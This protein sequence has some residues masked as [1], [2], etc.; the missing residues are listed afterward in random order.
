MTEPLA[1]PEP[2]AAADPAAPR[3]RGAWLWLLPAGWLAQVFVRLLLTRGLNAPPVY[4]DEAGYLIAARWFTGG[5]AADLSGGTF[6]QGGY[7]LLLTPAYLLGDDPVTVYRLALGINALIGATA[8]PL[9]F[10]ALRRLGLGRA[11][12]LALAWTA[13][14]LPAT[15]FWGGVAMSD[16]LLPVLVLGCLLCLDRFLRTHGAGAGAAASALA[17]YAMTVHS[18]GTVVLAVHGLV[19]AASA[20]R[21]DTRRAAL[22]GAGTA[23]L[24]VGAAVYFN[25]VVRDRLYPSGSFQGSDL[26]W[27]RLTTLDGQGWALAGAVGQLWAMLAATWMLGGIGLV[28]LWVVAGRRDTPYAD[29]VM[30][31]VVL[32]TTAGIAYATAAGL[33]DEIRY[34]NH[35]YGRYLSCLAFVYLLVGLAA[36]VRMARVA[37]PAALAVLA[38]AACGTVVAWRTSG[39]KPT[40]HIYL[41]FD[42]PEVGLLGG[43]WTGLK[44]FWTTLTACGLLVLFCALRR[45]GPA[46]LVGLLLTANLTAGMLMPVVLLE[47]RAQE[48]PP[49]GEA[50]RGGVAVAASLNPDRMRSLLIHSRLAFRVSWTELEKFDPAGPPRPGICAVV[51]GQ[52]DGVAPESTWPAHPPGWRARAAERRQLRWVVWSAPSCG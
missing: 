22:L 37:K 50:G 43:F 29:R 3:T 17:C 46:A 11:T 44:P 1:P 35:A 2:P 42:F 45:F 23:V 12:A 24:G 15:T 26:L 5:P 40:T 25:S 47:P 19:L 49:V 39:M 9:G 41:A 4:P 7:A 48:I 13:A 27:T 34:G 6:Y 28:L 31:V 30:A 38:F 18:R 36:L 16:A 52:P 32:T 14:L 51:V 20:Y 8:F 33:P 21:R 10:L